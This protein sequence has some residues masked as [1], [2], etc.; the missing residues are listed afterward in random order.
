MT[1][2]G[3]ARM[4][5]LKSVLDVPTADSGMCSTSKWAVGRY[6]DLAAK[7]LIVNDGEYTYTC[8]V[9]LNFNHQDTTTLRRELRQ[10]F[11]DRWF[12]SEGS[13][14]CTLTVFEQGEM[15]HRRNFILH[16]RITSRF[17][18]NDFQFKVPRQE[19]CRLYL[20]FKGDTLR[21][22]WSGGAAHVPAY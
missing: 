20:A 18:R 22:I 1:T 15:V 5:R 6:P 14:P 16:R 13:Y 8:R 3:I 4:S 10:C 21:S 11:V 2:L 17:P 7:V 12:D 19:W 9:G